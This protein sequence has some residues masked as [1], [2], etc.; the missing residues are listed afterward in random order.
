M[1]R[2]GDVRVKVPGSLNVE[3]LFW[4]R[5]YRDDSTEVPAENYWQGRL[6]DLSAN[7]M[8]IAVPLEQSANFRRG[9]L[10]GLQFTPMPYQKPIMIE[11]Q[12]KHVERTEEGTELH[13]GI[14]AL[15]LEATSQGREKLRKIIS[16]LEEYNK[17]ND[18]QPQQ[19]AGPQ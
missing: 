11:G 13:L 4:H 17:A 7:G 1:Q 9:Q 10:V 8:Q 18:C 15:G 19:A 14:Q 5:G 6:V 2:R 3:V 16:I 12:V